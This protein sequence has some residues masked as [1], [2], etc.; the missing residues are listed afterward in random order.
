L[1]SAGGK[2]VRFCERLPPA[3]VNP[4][5]AISRKSSGCFLYIAQCEYEKRLFSTR[6]VGRWG[7]LRTIRM[8]SALNAGL[9]G[10]AALLVLT[11]QGSLWIAMRNPGLVEARAMNIASFC[12]WGIC[13][14]AFG[15]I[16]LLLKEHPGIGA[17]LAEH[18]LTWLLAV[19]A[20]AGLF[21]VRE[22]LS[23]KLPG[24]ALISSGL[25]MAGALSS[26]VFGFVR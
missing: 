7:A 20:T 24:P 26:G 3:F 2:W 11:M 6:R 19:T 15:L 14:I 9:T 13:L 1:P 21:G 8:Q 4:V 12:H 18:P 25:L 16:L 5:C 22:C 23:M 17:G 10:L